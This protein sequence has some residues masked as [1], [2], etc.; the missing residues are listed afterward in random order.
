MRQENLKQI[1][2][3]ERINGKRAWGCQ[4]YNYLDQLK[5]YT[6][7]N[8]F[9]AGKFSLY[10]LA[11][12]IIKALILLICLTTRKAKMLCNKPKIL[13]KQS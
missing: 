9:T 11:R 13:F 1:S 6:K 8:T 4:K 12:F 7:H 2:T 3:I 5:A 10:K